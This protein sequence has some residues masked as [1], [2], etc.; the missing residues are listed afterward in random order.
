MDEIEVWEYD[1]GGPAIG[2]NE[3]YGSV[4]EFRLI[5]GVEV[6]VV[7]KTAPEHWV[8]AFEGHHHALEIPYHLAWRRPS[9]LDPDGIFSLSKLFIKKGFRS[10]LHSFGEVEDGY[11]TLT[12][13]CRR[14][15]GGNEREVSQPLVPYPVIFKGDRDACR[16]LSPGC[17]YRFC[18]CDVCAGAVRRNYGGIVRASG[19]QQGGDCQE[20]EAFSHIP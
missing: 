9:I 6:P 7:S 12:A 8:A 17:E 1:M 20:G 14:D 10:Q 15:F 19:S 3:F 18:P 4:P 5:V 11:Q 2:G 16:I 13:S